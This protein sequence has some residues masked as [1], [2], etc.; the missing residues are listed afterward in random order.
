MAGNSRNGLSLRAI[1]RQL[2]AL[3]VE[4]KAKLSEILFLLAE[5]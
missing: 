4:I 3:S 1:S 2:S 5:S